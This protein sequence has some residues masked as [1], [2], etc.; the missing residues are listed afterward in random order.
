LTT[1][2]LENYKNDSNF[3]WD[4]IDNKIIRKDFKFSS[5]PQTMAFANEVARLAE[6]EG[7]HPVMHIYFSK[8]TIEL[9][10][11]VMDGLSENDFIMAAKIDRIHE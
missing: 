7:H 9:W 5:Y 4:I 1:E 10:T 8:V 2:E 6:N 3:N 11:H